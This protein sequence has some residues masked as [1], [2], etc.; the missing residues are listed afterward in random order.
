GCA[1][2]DL[3]EMNALAV[4][5]VFE[6]VLVLQAANNPQVCAEQPNRKIVLA[7]ERQRR[8]CEDAADGSEWKPFDVRVLRRVLPNAEGLA[9]WLRFRIADRQ[10][11][12]LVRRRQ[13]PLEQN[14]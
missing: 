2:A 8:S 10:R 5:G 13:I 9:G 1:T 3:R 11:D 6:L 12:D 14:R 7:V 4:D